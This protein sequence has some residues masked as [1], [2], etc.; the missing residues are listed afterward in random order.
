MQLEEL[1]LQTILTQTVAMVRAK[2]PPSW[3]ACAGTSPPNTAAT[4]RQATTLGLNAPVI[5]CSTLV[6]SAP[7]SVGPTCAAIMGSVTPTRNPTLMQTERRTVR[8]RANAT[9]TFTAT[10]ALP[11][12][13]RRRA[14]MRWPTRRK[15]MWTVVGPTAQS[16]PTVRVAA[17]NLTASPGTAMGACAQ[18]LSHLFSCLAFLLPM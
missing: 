3:S 9:D 4:L 1:A 11:T 17:V 14:A 6:T 15:Q 5:P 18:R 10:T 2:I 12:S 7:M 8:A 13:G 16:A